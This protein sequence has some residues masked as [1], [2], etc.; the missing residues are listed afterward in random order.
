MIIEEARLRRHLLTIITIMCWYPLLLLLLEMLLL[1]LLGLPVIRGRIL[2]KSRRSSTVLVMHSRGH[3]V[4]V[5][6]QHGVLIACLRRLLLYRRLL[7][8]L[9]LCEIVMVLE[10]L[11][12]IA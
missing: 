7:L 9:L 12:Q 11:L 8:L 3:H 1:L 5:G 4:W 2:H 6:R 10:L